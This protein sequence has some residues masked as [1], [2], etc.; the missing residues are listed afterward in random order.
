METVEW[1]AWTEDTAKRRRTCF[2]RAPALPTPLMM[3]L[4]VDDAV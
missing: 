4:P 3:L 1:A 2:T